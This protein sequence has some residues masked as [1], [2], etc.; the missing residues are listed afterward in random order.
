MEAYNATNPPHV[1]Q[2]KVVMLG[3]DVHDKRVVCGH[4][5]KQ[6]IDTLVEL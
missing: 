1:S 4:Y 5:V 2:D 6:G 3:T